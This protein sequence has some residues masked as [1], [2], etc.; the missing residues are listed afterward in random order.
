M[1]GALLL[2]FLTAVVGIG[3]ANQVALHAGWWRYE[4]AD[5]VLLGVPLD[6]WIGWAVLWGPVPLLLRERV[7]VPVPVWAIIALFGWGDVLVMPQ[8]GMLVDLG[9]NWLYGELV[10]LVV[11]AVPAV[12]VGRWTVR[13]ERLAGRALIQLYAFTGLVM[14]L[15]PSA[16]MAAGD[17]SWHAL[18][19]GPGWRTA[20]LAAAMGVVAVPALLAMYE[21][22]RRGGGTPYPWDPPV[23]L[24]TT[25]P[26]A[27]VANPMQISAITLLGLI[28]IG[29]RSWSMALA[30]LGA[31]AFSV[32]LAEPH[33]R[34]ELAERLGPEWQRYDSRVRSWRIGRRPC[35]VGSLRAGNNWSWSAGERDGVGW[36][37]TPGRS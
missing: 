7:P 1:A 26:Y 21:F 18:Y 35:R 17:G 34:A 28:A 33:E 11:A 8:L 12:L 25:G 9:P 5:G 4:P 27:Y 3:F 30:T 37:R 16:V 29:T 10:A 15:M 13:R 22:A 6:L 23:R 24:V 20:G 36:R 2:A 14:W 32:A 31:T 19:A